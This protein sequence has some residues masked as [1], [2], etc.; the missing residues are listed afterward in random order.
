MSREFARAFYSSEAW[1]QTRK[2]YRKSV[3]NLCEVCLQ[4]GLITPGAIVHHRTPLTPETIDDPEM[5]LG[6]ENL[7]L[8]C[9]ECHA[10]MHGKKRRR[11]VIDETGAVFAAENIRG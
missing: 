7:Q 10:E 6:W 1:N 11:Y 9:R 4:K 3:G 5:T 2:A 8:L